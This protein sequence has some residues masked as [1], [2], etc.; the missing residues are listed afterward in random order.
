MSE[1]SLSV[2]LLSCLVWR[3]EDVDAAETLLL[4]FLSALPF[5]VVDF[6]TAVRAC[7]T[8]LWCFFEGGSF[9]N[10]VEETP[11]FNDSLAVTVSPFCSCCCF[12]RRY[13][14][15]WA[16][17]LVTGA[18]LAGAGVAFF[19][20]PRDDEGAAK[21]FIC[22]LTFCGGSSLARCWAAGGAG[23]DFFP[24][25]RRARATAAE[26]EEDEDEEDEEDAGGTADFLA[27]EE[28]VAGSAERVR[29]EE[30]AVGCERR[31]RREE[32]MEEEW[33]SD[34]ETAGEAG[35]LSFL[36]SLSLSLSLS[37]SA[38]GG[39]LWCSGCGWKNHDS[40]SGSGWGSGW[41]CVSE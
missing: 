14:S 6:I 20:T 26:E 39:C 29:A 23:S 16:A 30:E 36:S 27:A 40:G 5:L 19:L 11:L 7:P 9:F 31:E 34:T 15:S 25:G 32:E 4:T 28:V 22:T 35:S 37:S 13:C 10:C 18:S 17:L 3:F 21:D 24:L 1:F 8:E 33:G 12:L 38:T 41:S 2:L